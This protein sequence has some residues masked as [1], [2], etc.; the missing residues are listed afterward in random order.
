MA[1]GD[2]FIVVHESGGRRGGINLDNIAA[3]PGLRI[4]LII[5][6]NDAIHVAFGIGHGGGVSIGEST[7]ALRGG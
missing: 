5:V 6:E 3:R 1:A 7:A 4:A 2:E